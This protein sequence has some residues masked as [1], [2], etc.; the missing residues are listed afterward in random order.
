MM[1]KVAK[2]SAMAFVVIAKVAAIQPAETPRM[3]S[4]RNRSVGWSSNIEFSAVT[5]VSMPL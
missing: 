2:S 4:I 3:A 5:T 1:V